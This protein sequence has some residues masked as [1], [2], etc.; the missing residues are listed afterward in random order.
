[1]DRAEYAV[2]KVKKSGGELDCFFS[3]KKK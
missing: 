3:L 2:F 1:M